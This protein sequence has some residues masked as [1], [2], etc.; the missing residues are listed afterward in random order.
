[1]SNWE[2]FIC[3]FLGYKIGS[4]IWEILG[5]FLWGWT[6]NQN[7]K[8]FHLAKEGGVAVGGSV[9][10]SPSKTSPQKTADH[11]SLIFQGLP[12]CQVFFVFF[13][14]IL[15]TTVQPLFFKGSFFSCVVFQCILIRLHREEPPAL[16]L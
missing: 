5:N 15:S 1:M 9:L 10:L 14:F 8:F 3:G 11:P 16:V 12:A 6:N 2:W 4:L 7:K 13:W